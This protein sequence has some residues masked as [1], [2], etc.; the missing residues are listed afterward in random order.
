MSS[1]YSFFYSAL[2]PQN[3]QFKKEGVKVLRI[4]S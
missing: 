2:E 4:I 1:E 3:L